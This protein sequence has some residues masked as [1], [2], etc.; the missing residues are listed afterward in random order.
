MANPHKPTAAQKY[1]LRNY[2]P[3]YLDLKIK[4]VYFKEWK[5]D[6]ATLR[7]W[8]RAQSPYKREPGDGR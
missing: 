7:A 6:Q 3:V 1:S 8:A 2:G 4:P 5:P